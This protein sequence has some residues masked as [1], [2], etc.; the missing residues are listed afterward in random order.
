M[1]YDT[2][3]LLHYFRLMPDRRMLFGMRGAV[4]TTPASLRRTRRRIRADFD[5]MFPAWAHV[6]TPHFWA[7]LV[8][9]SRSLAPF[10]GPLPDMPGAY[11]ALAYH[12][13]GLAMGSYAGQQVAKMALGQAHEL[14]GFMQAPLQRFPLGRFRRAILPP[15]YGWYGVKDRG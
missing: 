8:C 6:E 13:N 11:A 3:H 2:R 9:L 10:A 1:C 12:G 5:A 7:G 14:P 15:V 4:R